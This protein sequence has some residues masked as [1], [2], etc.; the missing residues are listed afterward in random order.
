MSHSDRW[1]IML[2]MAITIAALA[3]A[4]YTRFSGIFMMVLAGCGYLITRPR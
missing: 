1:F 4:D 2:C 3:P